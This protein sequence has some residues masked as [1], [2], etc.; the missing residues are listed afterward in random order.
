MQE[1]SLD[2]L[3]ASKAGESDV[4]VVIDSQEE[5]VVPTAKEEF[6]PEEVQAVEKIKNTIDFKNVQTPVLYA[7]S[8][9]KELC[10]LSSNVLSNIKSKDLGETGQLLS[11]LLT[12]VQDFDISELQEDK[13][14]FESLFSK[15]K[16]KIDKIMGKYQVV[17]KQVDKI[18]DQLDISKD[19]LMKDTILFD[20]LYDENLKYF[21]ELNLYIE[22][23]EESISD[24]R[25]N[26]LPKLM[27]EAKGK[28]DPM[29][30]QVVQDYQANIDRFEKKIHDLKTTRMI[31]LQTAPQIK[32]IQSNS[33]LLIDKIDQTLANTV[34]LWK[35]QMIIA[36][37]LEH[38]GKIAEMQKEIS[39]ITNELLRKN[40]DK[41]KQNTLEVAKEAQRS[42]VDIESV[43][44]ANEQLISTIQD[45]IKINEDAR[46][47]RKN[48]EVELFKLEE[49][50]KEEL[51]KT[52]RG[53]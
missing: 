16:N 22:A 32:L 29:A 8:T 27:Q 47:A 20:R 7:S 41:L 45:S 43:K 17:E 30:M 38:Q 23:G 15:S 46:T 2:E 1:V 50:L 5:L 49:N 35:S 52:V 19:V 31:A 28:S 6:S 21:K 12:T 25:T 51:E 33:S 13:G 3:M 48:A 24:V 44:Y 14:F 26:V 37:G 18:A 53:K 34:P 10:E 39:D 4:P 40:A 9:Q 42:I 11:N 36:L